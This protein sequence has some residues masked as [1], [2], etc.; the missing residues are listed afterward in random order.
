MAMGMFTARIAST[1][2]GAPH[3][4]FVF[5]FSCLTLYLCGFLKVVG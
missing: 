1:V 5:F 4:C 2:V 3:L